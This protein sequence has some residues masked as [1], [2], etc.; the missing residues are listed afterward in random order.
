MEEGGGA[1]AVK[2]KQ[3]CYSKDQYTQRERAELGIVSSIS[4]NY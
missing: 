4:M 2:R 3:K 1:H